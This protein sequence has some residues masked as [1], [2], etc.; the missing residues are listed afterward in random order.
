MSSRIP[1]YVS[2]LSVHNILN[3]RES[4]NK[5]ESAISSSWTLS[6][7][8]RFVFKWKVFPGH[9]AKQRLQL[10]R[11]L[12]GNELKI[13]LQDFEGR[14]IFMSMYNDIDWTAKTEIFLENSSLI[15]DY[16]M[17][18]PTRTRTF[19]GPGDENKWCV[20]VAERPSGEWNRTAERM[21][22]NF[23]E[24]ILC[25]EEPVLWHEEY[26]KARA[27]RKVSI[28]F[29]AE[30]Q[31]AD[32]FFRSVLAARTLS[33]YGAVASWSDVRCEQAT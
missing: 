3:E 31:T 20:T 2:V 12:M 32:L 33:I 1:R 23:A 14:A 4:A 13:Q 9:T 29:N 18:L 30:P 16:A 24:G 26:C 11:K 10:I 15:F 19:F 7:E 27:A 28:H 6:M 25:S 17:K 21:M 5:T 22:L 8:N